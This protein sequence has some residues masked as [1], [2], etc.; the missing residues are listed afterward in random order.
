MLDITITKIEHEL[1][2]YLQTDYSVFTSKNCKTNTTLRTHLKAPHKINTW[3]PRM[4]GTTANRFTD[5]DTPPPHLTVQP[6][7]GQLASWLRDGMEYVR[8]QSEGMGCQSKSGGMRFS[9]RDIT[10]SVIHQELYFVS[11]C[12]I[13]IGSTKAISNKRLFS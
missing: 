13:T 12:G 3:Q 5:L 10:A 2:V 11:V 1:M 4:D 8:K 6:P 7:T 9:G